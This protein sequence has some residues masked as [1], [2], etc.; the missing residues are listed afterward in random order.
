MLSRAREAVNSTREETAG[1]THGA[2]KDADG[3]VL[4]FLHLLCSALLLL[5]AEHTG[6]VTQPLTV[7]WLAGAQTAVGNW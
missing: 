7:A 6:Q 2:A 3:A 5:V 4:F 1:I